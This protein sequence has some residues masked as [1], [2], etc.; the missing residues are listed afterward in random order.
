MK[1]SDFQ[2]ILEQ[3][4]RGETAELRLEAEGQVFLRRFT[5]KMR[6]ILLGG[7]H[8]A[9][10]LC[11]F[12]AMLD[13]AVTVCD[14]RPAFANRE[15][16]PEAERV[17]CDSFDVAIRALS[18]RPSDAVCVMTRGHRWDKLCLDTVFAGPQPAYLGMI[19]S[20]RR[21]AGLRQTLLEEGV[22][23]A[24]V[25]AL[26][27]PVGLPIGAV[28]PAEIAVSIC[29][30]LIAHRASGRKPDE[31]GVLGQT[32]AELPMLEFLACSEEPK[33]VLTAISATGST[34]AKP[35]AMMAV[36]KLG[37]VFGTVGGGCAEAAAMARARR[38]IGTG[39]SELFRVDLTNEDAADQGMV[40]GG[41]L[42]LLLADVTA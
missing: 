23:T 6:L 35:G 24:R 29:A 4:R 42:T 32:L 25:E 28:T 38:L 30:E 5:P 18:V 14:D 3:L 37:S 40:C 17:I 9:K 8:V 21:T 20:H 33:A 19:G 16:F 10:A 13:Y 15:R 36:G 31:D 26:H 1:Q 41:T 27:A 22:D 39:G 12:A 7:G 34:P 2:R 11:A